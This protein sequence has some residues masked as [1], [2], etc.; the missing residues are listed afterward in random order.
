MLNLDENLILNCFCSH[1]YLFDPVSLLLICFLNSFQV[2]LFLVILFVK[3][4][5][6]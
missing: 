4:H 6:L 5:I 3:K 1:V 2:I